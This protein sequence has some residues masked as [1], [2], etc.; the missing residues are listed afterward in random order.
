M[1]QYFH[2]LTLALLLLY[3]VPS[4][5]D[6]Q[7]SALNNQQRRL[8]TNKKRW[9]NQFDPHLHGGA[10]INGAALIQ[11]ARNKGDLNAGLHALGLQRKTSFKEALRSAQR[12]MDLSNPNHHESHRA[13]G[14]FRTAAFPGNK[15][16]QWVKATIKK[17]ERDNSEAFIQFTPHQAEKFIRIVRQ[18]NEPI[19]GKGILISIGRSNFNEHLIGPLFEKF[20]EVRGLDIIG[21]EVT[22]N[23]LNH[24]R[25]VVSFLQS[26]RE[27][28]VL[29]I[30]AGEGFLGRG[31]EKTV[32]IVL[33]ELVKLSRKS[34]LSNLRVVL[35]H[36]A[37]IDDVISAKAHL[38]EL[39]KNGVTVDVNINPISN[40]LYGVVPDIKSIAAFQLDANSYIA[41]T[42]NVGSIEANQKIVKLAL[43]GK[44]EK[45][46]HIARH[47][48]R[49][50][51]KWLALE[52]Q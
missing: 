1:A 49:L 46:Q 16:E 30:H 43:Q 19:N 51:E 32:N 37:K 41:G 31:G 44:F 14:S 34:D 24:F 25:R 3:N 11:L 15:Y 2:I 45:A 5:A 20:S 42:D 27:Q 47:Y 7:H 21:K 50:R 22:H 10:I 52:S 26:H 9:T 17:L 33:R 28:P 4:F 38:K 29:R 48:I 23:D 35:G 8:K 36:A 13:I 12:L 40:L 18:L 6:G 39:N